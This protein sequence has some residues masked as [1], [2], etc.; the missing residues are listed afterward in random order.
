MSRGLLS[1]DM[2]SD[3]VAEMQKVADYIVVRREQP[4]QNT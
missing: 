3:Y 4:T 1:R 2:A